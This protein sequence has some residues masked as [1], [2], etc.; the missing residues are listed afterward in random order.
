MEHQ[1]K[2]EPK[3]NETKKKS[4]VGTQKVWNKVNEIAQSGLQKWDYC[5]F[6]LL[7]ST[8]GGFD[9]YIYMCV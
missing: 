6:L 3:R 1:A 7:N 9:V 2:T 8:R 5:I 4:G